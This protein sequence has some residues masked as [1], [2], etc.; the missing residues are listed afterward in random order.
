MNANKNLYKMCVGCHDYGTIEQAG[1]LD[2]YVRSCPIEYPILSSGRKCPCIDCLVKGV[3][4][5][6]CRKYKIYLP[7]SDKEVHLH[8]EYFWKVRRAKR[9]N[10]V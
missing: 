8:T 5:T 4:T 2:L 1:H 9:G 6:P 7:K 3:C 10:K